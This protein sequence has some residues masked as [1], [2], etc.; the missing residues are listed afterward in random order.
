VNEIEQLKSVLCGPDGK[1]CIAGSDDDRAIVDAALVALE[2]ALKPG[3][4]VQLGDEWTF[5]VK[6]PITV[7]V[8]KQRPGEQH[9]STREGITP[10]RPD[11]LIMRGVAGEEYPIGRELFQR[12]Y[13]IGAAP[14]AQKLGGSSEAGIPV[15]DAP[16]RREPLSVGQIEDI[17]MIAREANDFI[18]VFARAIEAAHQIGVKP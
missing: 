4:P 1:C 5:C 10:V 9:V 7:H 13:R 15:S 11:D 6:L 17:W 8:R 12:T 2:A 16:P 3:E 14:P 18:D